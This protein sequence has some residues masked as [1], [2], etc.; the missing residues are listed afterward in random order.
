MYH[1]PNLIPAPISTTLVSEQLVAVDSPLGEVSYQDRSLDTDMP[2]P[3]ILD[4]QLPADLPTD[5][6]NSMPSTSVVLVIGDSFSLV[7]QNIVLILVS[8]SPKTKL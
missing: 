6:P 1:I 5:S 3:P 7:Y 8:I 2:S 4:N